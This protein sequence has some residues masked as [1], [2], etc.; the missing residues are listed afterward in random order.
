VSNQWLPGVCAF[1][2]HK[3]LDDQ[4]RHL[5]GLLL[6]RET[7]SIGERLTAVHAGPEA[8]VGKARVALA[9]PGEAPPTGIGA[10]AIAVEYAIPSFLPVPL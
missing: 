10:R 8:T 9:G 7:V 1:M 5:P 4:H 6:V 3:R 2:H